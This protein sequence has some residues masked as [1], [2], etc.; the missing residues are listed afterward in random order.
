MKRAACVRTLLFCFSFAVPGAAGWAEAEDISGTIT[1]TRIIFEDSQ[2]VGDVTCTMTDVPCIDF[3]AP[4]ITLRLNGF[5]ITGPAEPDN[6]PSGAAFC[7]PT[8]GAPAADG[9]RISNQANTQIL[10][11]GL[12]QR[13]RRHGIIILGT[14]G[15][16]TNVRVADLTTNHNCFSGVQTNGM[17]QSVIEGIVSVRNAVNSGTAPCGGNCL[18]N[19]NT[20]VIRRNLFAG[21]GSVANNNDDF[22]IGLIGSS[23]GNLIE[24]NIIGGNTN[25]IFIQATA[26]GNTIRGNVIAGNPPGQISRDYGASIGADVKDVSQTANTGARNT[27]QQNWCLTYIGPGPAPC[28]S[29]FIQPPAAPAV[30]TTGAPGAGWVCVNGGWVPPDHPLAGGAPVPPSP[31]PPTA[32]PGPDPFAP[33][34]GLVGQCINGGWVPRPAGGGTE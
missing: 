7:N 14:A 10:G 23:S 12:I 33:I 21:N 24:D 30:C 1:T 8:S 31:A 4:N 18:I 15:T 26:A 5:T 29:L 9:V 16:P 20:N 19:S 28:P 34:P 25:G 11:P 13:F 32:C 22:G 17:S 2:L 3:G 27:F 6:A